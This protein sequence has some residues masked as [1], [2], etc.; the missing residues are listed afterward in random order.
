MATT[1]TTRNGLIVIGDP[2]LVTPDVLREANDANAAILDQAV[3]YDEGPIG[4]RPESSPS[5]PG[6]AGRIYRST[7]ETPRVTYRDTG[8]GWYV[9]SIPAGVIWPWGGT[10]APTGFLLCQGQAV[11]RTTYAALFDAIGTGY[12]AGDGTTTFNL[13]DGSGGRSFVGPGTSALGTVFTRGT[14]GGEEKHTL[15][16]AEMPNHKH[17]TSWTGAAGGGA[18]N[19]VGGAPLN[20]PSDISAIASTGGGVA[21]NNMPL[22]QVIGGFIIKA[23]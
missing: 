23:F 13:P 18:F 10:S 2:E 16:I 7:D 3:L 19:A 20:G 6:I 15:T 9:D 11:S 12:G 8:T 5:T 1:F 14:K 22:Y 4:L 17:E 21:H